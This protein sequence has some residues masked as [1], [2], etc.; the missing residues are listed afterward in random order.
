MR[1]SEKLF[2]LI[3]LINLTGLAQIKYTDKGDIEN[4]EIV[5]EKNKKITFPEMPR[6]IEKAVIQKKSGTSEPKL[7]EYK[8]PSG[9]LPAVETKLR[10]L[11]IKEETKELLKRNFLRVGAGNYFTTYAEGSLVTKSNPNYRLGV[12]ARHFASYWG[13]VREVYS[14]SSQNNVMLYGN[15]FVKKNL[16]SANVNY[17]NVG[18]HFY[19][20]GNQRT[21]K[22]AAD[23]FQSLTTFGV[24]ARIE[25]IDT[26]AKINYAIDASFNSFSDKYKARETEIWLNGIGNYQ[27]NDF[28]KI[29]L[30]I[31]VSQTNRTDSL[32]QNRIL[33]QIKP[34]YEYMFNEKLTLK[35]GFNVAYEN[36]TN[37]NDKDVHLYPVLNAQYQVFDKVKLFVGFDG[38]M[39]R[40]IL[41][42]YANAN[43]YIG[44]NI[45]LIHSNRLWEINGGA[46][47]NFLN[48]GYLNTQ[49]S[50]SQYKNLYLFAPSNVDSSKYNVIYANGGVFKW[51]N[52]IDFKITNALKIGAKLDY[53]N[54]SLDSTKN[55]LRPNLE[56]GITG[57]YN[58]YEKLYF[59]LDLTYVSGLA[60]KNFKSGKTYQLPDI[61]DVTFRTNYM[62]SK[63][64]NVFLYFFNILNQNY[65]RIGYYPVRG[66]TVVGGITFSF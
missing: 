17:E 46:K 47:G 7:H 65:Q 55:W 3:F 56:L 52:N 36:D 24:Q 23:V 19:G 22:N 57:Q 14:G 15:Y 37:K 12:N 48:Y 9:S 44:P 53:Y 10:L 42:T 49:L 2:F 59:N 4:T 28:N 29:N 45:N 20:N 62:I 32:V 50:Y 63:K 60:I 25:K 18:V 39:E 11:S 66:I 31:N 6:T 33:F 54:Y 43:P 51:A 21:D 58:I 34:T 35:G 13:P 16:L 27:I 5:I 1:I 8:E 41:R 40:N 30:D 38:G 61:I 64:L 26:L